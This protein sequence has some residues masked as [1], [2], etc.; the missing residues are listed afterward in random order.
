MNGEKKN[1]KAIASLVL[2]I[3]SAAGGWFGI[4]GGILCLASGIVGIV[5]A[6]QAKKEMIAAGQETGMATAGMVL[7]IIGTVLAGIAT[8]ACGICLCVGGAAAS[9]IESE[10]GSDIDWGSAL[11]E[12]EDA[13]ESAT[14]GLQ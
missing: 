2:G 10:V 3:V 1:G 4:V 13:L 9:A 6:S 8:V 11:E 12:L 5:L 14:Q 7:S